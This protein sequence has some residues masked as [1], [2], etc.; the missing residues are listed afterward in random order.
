[1]KLTHIIALTFSIVTLLFTACTNNCTQAKIKWWSSFCIND[2][3]RNGSVSR[4]NAIE[5][6]ASIYVA[7]V[8]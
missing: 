6:G 1:M 5:A 7:R 3:T 8:A 4:F 2:L